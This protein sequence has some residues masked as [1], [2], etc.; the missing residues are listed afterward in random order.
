MKKLIL[1]FI[2]TL[3][4]CAC[5]QDVED[6]RIQVDLIF[7]NGAVA[8]IDPGLTVAS[9]VAVK[10]E[11][12]V[13]VGGADLLEEYVAGTMIDLK[14]NSLIPGF[15]D[16][17]THLRGHSRRY[18]DL[19]KT[20]SIEQI[21]GLVSRKVKE[22]GT[23]EWISGYGWSE[24]F[25]AEERRPLRRDLDEAAP[26][27][28][29]LLTRAGGHSAVMNS[30]ALRRAEVDENTEQPEGGVIEKD[31]AGRL[32]GIIRERQEIVGRLIPGATFDE[33]KDSLVAT[34]KAQLALGITSFTQATGSV[35][36]SDQQSN[37]THTYPQWEQIYH[38]YRGELPRAYIQVFWEGAESME[39]FGK[40][41]GEGD[42]HLRV[43]PVK[44][45]VDG[46]FTGPAAYTKEPYRGESTYRGHLSIDPDD[47]TLVI[48]EL[49]AAGWQSG[50]HAIGD[51][52]I[53]LVVDEL[54]A[55][56]DESPRD[57]HRHYLNH[58]TVM[59]SSETMDKMAD[60]GIAITQQPN[61]TY[62]LEGR[63]VD[64]LDGARLEHNNPLRSPMD[65][66]IHV[67]ISSDVL[68]IGPM[69][70]LYSAVTR[71]GMSGRV[72]SEEERLTMMEALR[73]Y[74]LFGAYLSFEE[75]IKGSIE[76]GKLADLVVLD[77]DLLTINSEQIMET[78]VL[79]TW[80]GGRLV[81]EY[82][83]S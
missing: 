53:E 32:N 63:Y 16:S 36:M 52:A 54:A 42:E 3:G 11:K 34:L 49:N 22:L 50:I 23:G 78:K 10:G 39:V 47:L 28:P 12:I 73:A 72:F 77:R 21:K 56:L 9:T 25:M 79:Q 57:D 51:A 35:A 4:F 37:W 67:A 65:H 62:T 83:G 14:G 46:G 20:T 41:S 74:T 29:V 5:S 81:Y 24:D 13:A 82:E 64:Y 18:I 7:H 70:G 68:P 31:D 17:H 40:R 44:I 66:G 55:A 61:F 59:P 60:Y 26:D 30:M 33:V 48:R 27:N 19:T 75:N 38:Q 6:G 45:F 15:I 58:F 8:T 69:V 71:K 43:G 80:L 76:P 2:A 1:S